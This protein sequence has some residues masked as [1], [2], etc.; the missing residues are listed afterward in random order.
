MKI[1]TYNILDGGIDSNGSR[2]EK[3]LEVIKQEA[4][5]FLALQETNNFEKND[6]KLLKRLSEELD[7]PYY[8]NSISEAVSGG[9]PYHV[10]SLSS[11]PFL[12][13]YIFPAVL[14]GG[15]AISTLINAP[16]GDISVCNIH[17]NSRS[18]NHRLRELA[19]ILEYQRQF[20]KQI[21]L[22]DHNDLSM[23]DQYD[24]PKEVA[25]YYDSPH[26]EVMDILSKSYIDTAFYTHSS[27]MRTFPTKGVNPEN[28]VPV[29]IDYISVTRP[30][31]NHVRKV[32]VV[33]TP[34]SDVASDHYP[35]T[36][37]ME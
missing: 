10:A 37:V 22:G 1:M 29:R 20:G 21:I 15:A 16:F 19:A 26:F 9:N 17:L 32:E 34:S 25:T 30:L 13:C 5:D 6:N 33:R 36:A 2:I 14:F 27:D 8:G 3:I 11:Y 31:V 18:K 23:T 35:V 7:L 4:P 28:E 12:K 24:L